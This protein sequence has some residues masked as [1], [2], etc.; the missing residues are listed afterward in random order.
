MLVWPA[1]ADSRRQNQHDGKLAA[2]LNALCYAAAEQP[3]N[4]DNCCDQAQHTNLDIG[5]VNNA[6]QVLDT[7]TVV[8]LVQNNDLHGV[9]V[10]PVLSTGSWGCNSHA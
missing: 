6:L 3:S 1:D 4:A 7:G 8:Q 2:S 5:L 10:W 9:Q